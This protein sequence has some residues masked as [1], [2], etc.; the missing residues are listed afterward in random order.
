MERGRAALQG[1]RMVA[2]LS[3]MVAQ[4][5]ARFIAS[6]KAGNE[7]KSPI[8]VGGTFPRERG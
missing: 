4:G 8:V 3:P 1:G 2:H 5:A 6:K 7:L